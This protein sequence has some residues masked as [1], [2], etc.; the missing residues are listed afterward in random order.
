MKPQLIAIVA[1]VLVV[2]CKSISIHE[3]AA[4]G[5]TESLKQ[6]L[7]A[8]TDVNQKNSYDGSTALNHAAWHGHMEIVQLL[9][10][11]G[12]NT[13]AKRNDG[14]TPL[15]DAATQGHEEIAEL[16]IANGADINTKDDGERTPL[17]VAAHEGQKNIAEILIAKGADVNA[18]SKD[19]RGSTPLDVATHPDNPNASAETANLLR[20]HGGKTGEELEAEGK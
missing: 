18:I 8:G 12:A 13:N 14:W 17:Y 16:L 6:Q 15:H 5:N 2:G 7:N 4:T 9:L 20:K 10:E 1:A 11:N 19:G 3:A